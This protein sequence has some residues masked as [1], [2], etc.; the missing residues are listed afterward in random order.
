MD[1]SGGTSANIQASLAGRYATALFEL[2]R[3]NGS[4]DAVEKSLSAVAR[5]ASESDD[6]KSLTTSPSI[7]RLDA[8]R[9][10][11]AVASSMKLDALTAKT[12][13]VLAQNRRLG[14]IAAV[15]RAFSVLAAA[16]RGEVTAEVTSAHPLSTA[17]MSA[18]AAKLKARVGSDVAIQTTVDPS[19]LGGLTV[20]IGSQMIDN[21]IKTRLNSL[22]TA[23]KG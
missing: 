15:A 11:S 21:S 14:E 12:L 23:M 2:A 22:A 5:A 8:Q 1:H 16:H 3:D 4:I 17:Q 9:A 19:I 10:I 7:T 6:L 18:L 13:G 20:R